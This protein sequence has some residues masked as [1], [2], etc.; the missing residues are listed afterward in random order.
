M[1][2]NAKLALQLDCKDINSEVSLI[3]LSRPP[4]VFT[5]SVAFGFVTHQLPLSCDKVAD[6][7]FLTLGERTAGV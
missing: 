2:T 7:Y 6:K 1:H 5:L 4:K 3:H